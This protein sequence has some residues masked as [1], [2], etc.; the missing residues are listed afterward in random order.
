MNYSNHVGH[1]DTIYVHSVRNI[2]KRICISTMTTP[3]PL[4]GLS[5][6]ARA[7]GSNVV[8]LCP[9]RLTLSAPRGY[10]IRCCP[11]TFYDIAPDQTPEVSFRLKKSAPDLC[12]ASDVS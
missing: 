8:E 6:K 11:L 9:E 10:I 3:R 12:G 4:H 7:W 1:T 2:L 5:A